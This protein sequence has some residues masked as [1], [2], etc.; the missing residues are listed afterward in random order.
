M[1]IAHLVLE[2]LKALL[3]PQDVAG[4]VVL[5]F[6]LLF[7]ED[8]KALL[9]RIAKIRFPDGT[10]VSTSQGER[11]ANEEQ[12]ENKPLPT[13]DISALVGLPEDL[14]PQQR[15]AIENILRA[16]KA[17]SYL[18]EY[19]YLN[20]FLVYRT[21]EVLN[22]LIGL[23]QSTTY[24]HYDATWLP[25]IPS[26]QER[27]AILAALETHH[28]IQVTDAVIQVTPKGKEYQQWRGPL[29]QLP[30]TTGSM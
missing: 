15:V 4:G 27:N 6:F 30:L 17:T 26:A 23:M 12:I 19:R 28:L 22:W 18:W 9:L 2:Y 11:K 10:E 24:S 3:S 16:E 20:Y 25:V 13:F 29:P 5:T 14:T 7:H 1:E 8:I 21:Q